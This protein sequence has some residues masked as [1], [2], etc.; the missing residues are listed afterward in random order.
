LLTEFWEH[1]PAALRIEVLT[2]VGW[3]LGR[4]PTL[5]AE[6]T[7]RFSAVWSWIVDE[8]RTSDSASLAG[9]GAWLAADALPATWR[10]DQALAVLRRDIHLQPNFAVYEALPKLV[11]AE[12]ERVLEILKRMITTDPEAYSPWG[13]VDE[14]KSTLRIAQATGGELIQRRAQ[15]IADLLVARGLPAF[16]DLGQT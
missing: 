12:P 13:S 4:T 15:E 3:S 5:D 8:A 11:E 9:F 1:A 10:L 14:I 6:M 7:D 16:R 2:S